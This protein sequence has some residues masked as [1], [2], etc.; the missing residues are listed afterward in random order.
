MTTDAGGVCLFSGDEKISGI[1]H[2]W[3]ACSDEP[4]LPG[5]AIT[6]PIKFSLVEVALVDVCSFL[7]VLCTLR[8]MYVGLMFMLIINIIIQ[9]LII[10]EVSFVFCCMDHVC[11]SIQF[12]SANLS[13]HPQTC[14]KHVPGENLYAFTLQLLSEG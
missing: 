10:F 5:V 6:N 9:V 8:S 1:T 11:I 4:Y 14:S 7:L 13:L 12:R 2:H 3:P